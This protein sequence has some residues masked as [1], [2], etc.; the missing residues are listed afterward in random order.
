[1]LSFFLDH[2]TK[3]KLITLSPILVSTF[4]HEL[5]VQ[6]T[7]KQS[8]PSYITIHYYLNKQ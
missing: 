7:D 2:I 1:M 4:Q 3:I 8:Y 6:T 5:W